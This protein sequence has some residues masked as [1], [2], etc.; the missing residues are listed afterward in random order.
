MGIHHKDAENDTVEV[1]AGTE[2]L[3]P[4]DEPESP[5]PKEKPRRASYLWATPKG[6]VQTTC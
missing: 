2:I 3:K 4:P 5:R 1:S 6:A